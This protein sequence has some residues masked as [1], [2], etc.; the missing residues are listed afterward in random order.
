MS[1]RNR[2]EDVPMTAWEERR[3]HAKGERHRIAAELHAV[4]VHVDTRSG[5]DDAIEPGPAWKP[6]HHHSADVAKK[7]AASTSSLRHWKSKAWKRRSAA[8]KERNLALG[9][10]ILEN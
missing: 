10:L 8:R 9:Q 1:R 4:A 2:S 6:D 5:I 7:Q 3:A